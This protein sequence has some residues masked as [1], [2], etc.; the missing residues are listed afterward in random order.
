MPG[1]LP[2]EMLL[3]R[4]CR[5]PSAWCQTHTRKLDTQFHDVRLSGAGVH[6]S[7]GTAGSG[8][9]NWSRVALMD[10]PGAR[11]SPRMYAR[12]MAQSPKPRQ[13]PKRTAAAK[14]PKL[15]APL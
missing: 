1:A 6:A 10:D 11:R 2:P 8:M 3:G 4:N 12:M 9:S 5:C 7:T 13:N 14:V 15:G